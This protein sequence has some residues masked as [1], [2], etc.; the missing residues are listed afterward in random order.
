MSKKLIICEKPSL[1][2]NVVKAIGKMNKNDGYYEN[3]DYIVTFEFGHLMTLYDVDDYI[4]KGEKTPWSLD[5]LPFFPKEF[6]RKIKDDSGV[7]K[8]FKIITSLIKRKDVEALVNCGDFDNEGQLLVDEL[9]EYIYKKENINKKV[10]RL[11]LP[12]QTMETIRKELAS[13][14][15]NENFQNFHNEAE[16]R[17]RLDWLIGI[18]YTRFLTLKAGS[19]F[20]VGRVL[21]PIVKFVYDRD[22]TIKNFVPEKYY[23]ISTKIN[24][25]GEEISL[26]F[27]DLKFDK[28]KKGVAEETLNALKGRK[29]IVNNIEQKEI[30]K[31]RPK[32]FSLDTLQNYCYK[33]YKISLANT[34][35]CCQSLYE[36]GFTTYP[37]T[38]SE[39]LSENEKDKVKSIINK[40]NDDRICFR[41]SKAIFD[42]SKIESHSALTPTGSIPSSL[43]EM[44]QKVYNAIL[45]R[46]KS[47]FAK[48]D[49]ILFNVKTAFNFEGLDNLKASLSSTSIKQKG[50]LEFEASS[51]KIY[52][53]FK[54]NEE[55]NPILN[56]D[57]KETEPPS[58]VNENELNKFLK[59][60]LKKDEKEEMSEDDE[61]KAILEGIEL[62]TVATRAGI[63]ENAYKYG[64]IVKDKNSISIT[65]KGIVFI[66]D[67]N[68]LQIDLSA[69]ETVEYSKSLKRIFNKKLDVDDFTKMIEDSIK[70]NMKMDAKV[71]TYSSNSS[72]QK[73]SLGKCPLCGGDIYE[74]TKAFGCYN[75]KEKDCKFVIWKTVAGKK[76]TKSNV[77]E[78]LSKGET[79]RIDGF[80]SKAGK[81]FSAK[82][83]LDDTGKVTFDFN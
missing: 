11:C 34:L 25:D 82:L 4:N 18:N 3:N 6:K 83:K 26:D 58:K 23:V 9:I 81:K 60:P 42:D 32:L 37:R 16:G 80:K 77:K 59:N 22:M 49:C 62:G 44:E 54:L 48:D 56:L 57:E 24:K 72:S 36:K 39:Y 13:L 5:I 29:I 67:L 40:L 51:E 64:Y 30:T 63:I 14:K 10:Y 7:R 46:F 28:D 70:Q 66:E 12:E 41:D 74:N 45:N 53:L 68:K 71:N 52:P 17:T 8:Q 31:T 43:S 75:W 50:Y 33:K 79:K 2:L 61:Y 65:P 27:K 35:K 38:N 69:K 21:T 19:L 15:P 47:T 76:L 73:E 55:F 1:A 20:P 78:L